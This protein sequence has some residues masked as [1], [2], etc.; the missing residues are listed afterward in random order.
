MSVTA[1]LSKDGKT[2]VVHVPM[3]FRKRGGRKL[4]VVPEGASW[5]PPR[6][7][8]DNAMVRALARAF[9]WRK[10]LETGVRASV[11][12]IAAAEEINTSYVSRILRLTLLAPEIVEAIL[13]G[14]RPPTLQLA[15]LLKAVSAEWRL[16]KASLV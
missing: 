14:R 3:A 1:N 7:R 11:E 9:R 13:D 12:E 2:L 4:I 10:L 6:A 15:Q 5:A 8:V 16:Q